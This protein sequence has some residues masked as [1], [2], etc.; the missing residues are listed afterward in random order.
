M[1]EFGVELNDVT[2][3]FDE[4]TLFSTK[5]PVGAGI[6]SVT[7]VGAIPFVAFIS[8]DDADATEVPTA[9]VAVTEKVYTRS[10]RTGISQYVVGAVTVHVAPPGDAVTVYEVIGDPFSFAGGSNE[11][12]AESVIVPAVITADTF[13]GADGRATAVIPVEASESLELPLLLTAF[14]VYV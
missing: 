7:S 14:T 5:S 13:N 10:G 8:R 4:S 6:G 3:T 9:F 12:V 11:T 2:S 1:T